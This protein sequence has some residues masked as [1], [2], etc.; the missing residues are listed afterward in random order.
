M[1][2]RQIVTVRLTTEQR[3]CVLRAVNGRRSQLREHISRL[4]ELGIER[5][6]N[7]ME[8]IAARSELEC[9]QNACAALWNE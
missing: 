1:I 2:L 3:A 4:E 8:V 5:G 7:R 9:L 6:D